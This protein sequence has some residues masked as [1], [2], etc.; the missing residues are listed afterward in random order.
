VNTQPIRVFLA[1]LSHRRVLQIGG[2]YIA[3]AWLGVEIFTFL[4]DQFLAPDWAYRL[5]GIILVVGFP[6]SMVLAWMIQV[7]EEGHWEIEPSHGDRKILGAAIFLGLL[8]TAGLSWKLLPQPPAPPIY[9][10]MPA[11][12][13]ILPFA[14]PAVERLYQTL[15]IGLEQSRE[16]TL[17]RLQ[18]NTRAKDLLTLGKQ[19]SVTNLAAGQSLQSKKGSDLNVRVLNVV[20]GEFMQSKPYNIDPAAS[21]D[22]AYAIANDLLES[23]ALPLLKREQFTGTGNREAFQ[24]YMDGKMHSRETDQVMKA[25]GDFQAAIDLDP[26]FVRAYVGLAQAIYEWLELAD[27]PEA[28]SAGLLDRAGKAIDMA[29]QINPESAEAL[30]LFALSL[31]NPQLRIQTWERALELD[32]N[33]VLSFYRYAVELKENGRLNDAERMVRRALKLKPMNPRFEAVLADIL[34]LQERSGNV[35]AN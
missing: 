17:V 14:E 19:L 22:T 9:E 21:T 6:I 26:G 29:R 25:I 32:P 10:P 33:H 31:E 13:A 5:L 34:D 15:I 8:I 27:S 3:G 11:S 35:P 7:S 12:L 20:T 16:L 18:Q 2:A 23:M 4:F 30:S 28:E 1:E 24:F